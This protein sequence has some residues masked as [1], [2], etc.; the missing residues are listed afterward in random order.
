M[1]T[2]GWKGLR[3]SFNVRFNSASPSYQRIAST[4][5][6]SNHYFVWQSTN[7]ST[8]SHSRSF[9]RTMD[10]VHSTEIRTSISLFLAVKLITTSALDNY[11]T[12]RRLTLNGQRYLQSLIIDGGSCKPNVTQSLAPPTSCVYK[13]VQAYLQA[14]CVPHSRPG[15]S[16]SKH[17]QH[18]VFA[19]DY[20]LNLQRRASPTLDPIFLPP[21]TINIVCLQGSA[22][23][24]SAAEC[25]DELTVVSI[26][27]HEPPL[28]WRPRN[29]HHYIYRVTHKST[30]VFLTHRYRI[31]YC[32]DMSPSLSAVVLVQGWRV[33]PPNLSEFLDLVHMQ[34]LDLEDAVSQVA[35]IAYEQLEAL[36]VESENLVGGLFDENVDPPQS[37]ETQ[38][39]M[40]S[41]DTSFI[42]MLRYGILASRLLPESGC[43]NIIVV[44]D[45]IVAIPDIHV[46]DSVLTQLRTSAVACSFL[47]VGSLF[48]PYCGKGLVPYIDLM[49]FISAATLGT[50]MTNIPT[51]T[52]I[53]KCELQVGSGHCTLTCH[54]QF[55]KMSPSGEDLLLAAVRSSYTVPEGIRSGM[56]V[57]YL[58][59]NSSM[60]SL[61]SRYERMPTDFTT[62]VFP[63]G[64]QPPTKPV[65]PGTSNVNNSG[66]GGLLT[67]LSRYLHHRR[68]VWAAQNG[69]GC[70]LGLSAIARILSTITKVPG[71]LQYELGGG[72][73]LAK[74]TG[75]GEGLD[76]S[77]LLIREA[78]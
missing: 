44:T 8:V 21:S 30:I 52:P 60:S 66:G 70:S 4:H 50:Y 53:G 55:V 5:S 19:R 6:S 25:K 28:E 41:P 68:W 1:A 17:Q 69:L 36:R 49:Q 47:H 16:P 40:V 56:P 14:A 7:S 54:K 35:G 33:T 59:A 78:S 26:Q 71:R 62:V 73:R 75:C 51:I 20:K 29:C 11:A 58:P 37:P 65:L 23:L 34:L 15:I 24:P 72:L 42:N 27:P 31:I 64:T 13:S 2:L 46:F 12:E 9:V 67:T 32:L 38:I 77:T 22:S 76:I 43:A 61:T 57:F 63:D 48:H 3:A 39:A 74:L 18:R 10:Q 45:G